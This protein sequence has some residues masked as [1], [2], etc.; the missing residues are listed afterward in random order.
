MSL[1][2]FWRLQDHHY[3]LTGR[4]CTHCGHT[5]LPPRDICPEC[6]P[7]VYELDLLYERGEG[8]FSE[9]RLEAQEHASY[10]LLV[11]DLADVPQSLT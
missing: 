7:P 6:H 4:V 8:L 5:S 9:T 11:S 2:R 3:G 10:V 1:P